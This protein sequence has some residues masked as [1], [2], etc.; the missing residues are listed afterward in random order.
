MG[1]SYWNIAWFSVEMWIRMLRHISLLPNH[2]FKW[3][4]AAALVAVYKRHQDTELDIIVLFLRLLCNFILTLKHARHICSFA[5]S[6]LLASAPNTIQKGWRSQGSVKHMEESTNLF[7]W[8]EYYF[9]FIYSLSH[10][11]RISVGQKFTNTK[12]IVSLNSLQESRNWFNDFEN[13]LISQLQVDLHCHCL[14]CHCTRK[15]PFP[16]IWRWVKT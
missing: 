14:K 11:I 8:E 4:I 5:N 6:H 2:S 9:K 12:L 3:A 7:T 15:K 1:T 16:E 10:D 13:L